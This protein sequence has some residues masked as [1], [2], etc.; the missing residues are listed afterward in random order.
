MLGHVPNRSCVQGVERQNEPNAK[1]KKQSDT[2]NIFLV[3]L[4]F[5]SELGHAVKWKGRE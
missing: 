1:T 3:Y 4:V 5:P 2:M